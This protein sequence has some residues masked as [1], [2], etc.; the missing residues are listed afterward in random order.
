MLVSPNKILYRCYNKQKHP[1]NVGQGV[2]FILRFFQNYRF[3]ENR[4]VE[5]N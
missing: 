4:L 5:T 1:A 3:T 2:S